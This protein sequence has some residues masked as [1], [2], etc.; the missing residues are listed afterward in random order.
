MIV[1]AQYLKPLDPELTHGKQV[2]ESGNHKKF[3]CRIDCALRN[4]LCTLQQLLSV[5]E[6]VEK[7]KRKNALLHRLQSKKQAM[8][9][10]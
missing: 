9:F 5:N 1:L 2:S 3:E 10:H 8:C 6:Q 7:Q 4:E